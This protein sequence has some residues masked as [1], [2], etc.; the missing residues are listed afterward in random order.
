MKIVVFV[1]LVLYALLVFLNAA[2]GFKAKIIHQKNLV[3][4]GLWTLFV[5]VFGSSYLMT[6]NMYAL[7][8]VAAGLF[9]YSSVAIRNAQSMGQMP[10]LKHHLIRMGIHFA[11]LLLLYFA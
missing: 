10:K 2:L 6:A 11:L 7:G 4:T 5:L 3:W 9:G 1:V 8:G